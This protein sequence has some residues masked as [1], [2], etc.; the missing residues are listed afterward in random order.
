MPNRQENLE[1]EAMLVQALLDSKQ[2]EGDCYAEYEVQYDF[3]F[4][5]SEAA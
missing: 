1:W 2:P 5:L 3:G 4:D